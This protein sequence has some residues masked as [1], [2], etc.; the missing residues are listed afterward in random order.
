M[1][2]RPNAWRVD[3]QLG[4]SPSHCIKGSWQ[5]DEGESVHNRYRFLVIAGEPTRSD[6]DA[7]WNKFARERAG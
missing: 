7:E 4:F 1:P 5:L 6:L 2:G 3:D